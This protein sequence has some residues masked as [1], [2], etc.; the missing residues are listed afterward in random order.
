MTV[1]P[2]FRFA[3][4]GYT[5]ATSIAL[6]YQVCAFLSFLGLLTW[7]LPDIERERFR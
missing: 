6:V 4:P 1:I 7:F 3:Q 5:A 2:G